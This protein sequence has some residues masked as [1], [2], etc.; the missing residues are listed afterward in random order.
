MADP[1]S[2]ATGVVALLGAGVACGKKLV[3][4]VQAFRNAPLELVVLSNEVSDL[5]TVLAA[6][7]SAAMDVADA[8]ARG[9]SSQ[10]RRL[11]P[12][13]PPYEDPARLA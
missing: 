4:T 13:L 8:D 2:I 12:P 7:E 6:I 5:I 9:V 3:S 1:L 11:N 10:D